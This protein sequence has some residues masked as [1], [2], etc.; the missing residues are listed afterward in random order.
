MITMSMTKR[1]AEIA[2]IGAGAA[3]LVAAIFA[4]RAG[5]AV[6]LFD[7]NDRPGKKLRITGKGRCN[8]TNNCDINEFLQNVPTN[9]RFLYS[10][11]GRLS[12]TDTMELFEEL[13]VA[14]KTERGRR[15][16]PESDNAHDVADA[17]VRECRR[18]GVESVRERVLGVKTENG[19]VTG[20][21]TEKGEREFSA[22]IVA[23]GGLSYPG[24]GSSGDGY[25]IAS[26][27]GHRVTE[28]RPSL[29]PIVAGGICAACQ[30][31][32]LKNVSLTVISRESSKAVY[33]DFGEMMFAHFG[34]TGPLVL[35]ASAHIPDIAPGKYTAR[36]DLKP[37][38]DEKTL[39]SRIL[40]DF[41]KNLNRDFCNSLSAL[42]P[43]K[44]IDPIVGLSGIEPR[45]K[46]NEITK[47]ERAR[48]VAL[49]K[50]VEIPLLGFRP[51][52]EAII[53][54]GGV[55]VKEIDPGT[56]ES[57][58]VDGLY[59][60]GEV[61]DLDAYTGGYNL[62]IAFSTGA[63]AGENAAYEVMSSIEE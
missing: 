48:L 29:V 59:F 6:A 21:E 7:K 24:T 28:R 31:L 60:A 23:T 2:V 62:Q 40:G 14:L 35:S 26:E 63:L 53:T 30:G 49:I 41:G 33:T 43:Q 36:I 37:A 39:D 34:L 57:K 55:D 16:F 38:L 4:A 10:A 15:V 17:L 20:I 58:K 3:G 42:L 46:V 12:P 47:V 32:S 44:L 9:P 22:V 56:M 18:L 45:K 50:G 8:V 54:K 61:L 51:I 25:R 11:L 5:G 52:N 19:R 13:G 1:K 27:T